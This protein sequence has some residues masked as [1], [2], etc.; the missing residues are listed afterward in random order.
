MRIVF[1]LI[2]LL[3][4]QLLL[5]QR[6]KRDV[7]YLKNGSIVRGTIVLQDPGKLIKLKTA[8]NSLWVFSNDQIDSITRPIRVHAPHK[9]GYFNLTELGVLAGNYANATKAPLSLLNISSWYFEKGFSTGLGVGIEFSN[10][11]YLPVVADFRYYFRDE[12]PL[13]FLTLQAG[14]AFALGGSYAETL[15]AVDDIRVYSNYY[16]G[17]YPNYSTAAIAAR[18][19]FLINPAIGLQTRLNDNLALT[20]SAGYRWMRHHYSRSVDDYKLDIDFNR[21]S[22]KIGL[23]FK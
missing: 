4:S 16:I 18:G 22:L 8:D 3:V 10:E 15:R 7:V 5:A 17:P 12:H 9:T 14:Y 20:F 13:P 2:A 23:L 11:T 1:L 6:G 19:G 21:M